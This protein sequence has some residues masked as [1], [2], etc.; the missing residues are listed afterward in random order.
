MDHPD[1]VGFSCQL[2]SPED[3]A[4]MFSI[5]NAFAACV[6]HFLESAAVHPSTAVW[7]FCVQF[8]GRFCAGWQKGHPADC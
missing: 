2:E 1:T 4:E 8:L 3:T 7:L 6:G 5:L